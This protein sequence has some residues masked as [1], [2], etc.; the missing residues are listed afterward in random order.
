[1]IVFIGIFRHGGEVCYVGR[2]MN[3]TQ[4][5]SLELDSFAVSTDEWPVC[6]S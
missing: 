3:E 1:M 2:K 6:N 4:I 5:V